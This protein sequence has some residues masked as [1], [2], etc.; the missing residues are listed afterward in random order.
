MRNGSQDCED[1]LPHRH[2]RFRPTKAVVKGIEDIEA[3]IEQNVR[4][5]G[6][7]E[8]RATSFL[9]IIK[10]MIEALDEINETLKA[11]DRKNITYALVS[12]VDS[13]LLRSS[14]DDRRLLFSALA[15]NLCSRKWQEKAKR[16]KTEY[17]VSLVQLTQDV[18]LQ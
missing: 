15:R 3:Y 2:L 10:D 18:V 4:A 7:S 16:L 14:E 1:F 5:E 12:L 6:P 9:L 8:D 11:Q 17:N 13:Y